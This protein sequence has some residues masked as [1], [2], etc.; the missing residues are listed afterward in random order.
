MT[1]PL[2][3]I[4]IEHLR[5]SVIPFSLEFEK[6]KKL[7]VIYGENGTGKSTICDAFEFI[8]KG[9]V[10]SLDN[11]GLGRTDRYW[12]SMGKS[13]SDVVVSLETAESSC[14]ATIGSKEVVVLPADR[15]PRVE[16]LRRK[17]ILDLIA[18][19]P[20]KRYA[21]ISHFVDVSAIENSEGTLRQLL[22]D[23]TSSREVAI[24]R[25]QENQDAIRQFWES[26]GK[27]G[28]NMFRWA[29]A[30]SSRDSSTHD[31]EISAIH[32]LGS[33]FSQLATYPDR[34]ASAQA[35]LDSA[36]DAQR[37]AQVKVNELLADLSQDVGEVVEILHAAQ[38]YL[39]KQTTVVETCPLCESAEKVAGLA[40]RVNHRLTS[41]SDYQLALG[42]SF[43]R[44]YRH[45][46]KEENDAIGG[47]HAHQDTTTVHGRI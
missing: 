47:P 39:A 13:P 15:H 20:G 33:A 11:R 5:G 40:D 41:F 31:A 16:V 27:P 44:L 3:K 18:A 7:T 24:A 12:H 43:P 35:S 14:R 9:K 4:T 8:G 32:A 23:L 22:K 21:A 28:P 1:Q 36:K 46:T 37:V 6:G 38:K 42:L 34:L 30:E 45:L 10:G 25:V 26:A 29:E 19:E 2:K 17:Q